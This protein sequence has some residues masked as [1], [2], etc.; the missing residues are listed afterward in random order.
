MTSSLK[1]STMTAVMQRLSLL[2]L[3]AVV[4]NCGG[5]GASL[6][7][8]VDSGGTGRSTA[9]GPVT[10]LG[11]VFVNGVR[12]QV[13]SAV[14]KDDDGK[15]VGPDQLTMG[16]VA[17]VQSTA[18]VN[19]GGELKAT[20]DMVQIVS[21][22]VG[23]VESVDVASNSLNVLGQSV[24][25]TAAT[26]FDDVF[27]NGLDASLVGQGVEIFGH[28]DNGA[29]QYVATRVALRTDHSA[30]KING[31]LNAWDP[32]KK[33]MVVGNLNV[34]YANLADASVPTTLKLGDF[35]RI[36]VPAKPVGSSVT[37]QSISVV[38][39]DLG[40]ARKVS[41][42]GR[43]TAWT[44]TR[45]FS[46]NGKAVNAASAVFPDGE[47]GAIL[48]ARIL[49]SG[50]SSHDTLVAS[51]VT[52]QG[53]ESAANSQFELHGAITSLDKSAKSMVVHG[54]AVKFAAQTTIA[55]GA[56]ADL[57]NG[58]QVKVVGTLSA[59]KTSVEAKSISFE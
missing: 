5:G 58:R 22:L 26:W 45:Q 1:K 47:S 14:I 33:T 24:R 20:A 36:R 32:V 21:Q 7:G 3:L 53:N 34:N 54:I 19:D 56:L 42:N 49:V 40:D 57:N 25:I 39:I 31:L 15:I 51:T 16:M 44:S 6:A 18:T 2:A 27:Q 59:S 50:I 46:V 8:G 29:K 4:T 35:V 23:P 10:G 11:S 48:G 9:S 55:A 17:T 43:I 38:V 30:Y 52:V 13:D 41:L 37:A 12:F 28:F